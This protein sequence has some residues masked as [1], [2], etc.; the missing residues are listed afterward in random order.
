MSLTDI[1]IRYLELT[2]PSDLRPKR[3][4]STG[5]QF[6]RVPGPMP[7]LN[8]FF[9]TTVGGSYKWFERRSWT[10]TEW[11]AY[12]ERPDVETWV[13]SLGGV[14]AGFV[15]YNR[16]QSGDIEIKYFGLLPTFVGHGLGAQLLTEAVER[17]WGMGASRVILDTCSTD[18]PRALP[19]YLARGFREYK[20][21]VKRKDIPD[22]PLSPW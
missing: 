18:H 21:E 10:V 14:P 17:A 4:E 15:E 8:R 7:E 6:V 2:S 9:Y 5:V 11:Q 1:T 19:N 13:L 3:S 20:V 22:H 12:L 16:H